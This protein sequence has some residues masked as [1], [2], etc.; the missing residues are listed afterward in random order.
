[1]PHV[2]R[3]TPIAIAKLKAG[4]S[5]YEVSE[6]ASPLRI[7]VQTSGHKSG[8]IRYRRPNTRETAKW[9]SDIPVTDLAALRKDAVDAAFM[10]SQG[11]DPGKAKQATE[12]KEAEVRADTFE[13]AVRTYIK[14]ETGKVKSMRWREK[15][16]ERLIL[17]TLGHRPVSTITL[18]E[19]TALCDTVE[20]E[21]GPAMADHAFALIRRVMRWH[22]KRNGTT[23]P[24]LL[25]EK[26]NPN[27]ARSRI[28]TDNEWRLGW[29]H[30]ETTP[31]VFPLFWMFLLH[32]GCR[33]GEAAGM[34]WSELDGD[35]WVL[36]PER[37]K[38]GLEVVRPLSK[39]ALR[40]LEDVPRVGPFVF[41]AT[42]ARPLS[43]FV[44]PKK[45]F[46]KAAGISGYTLHDLRRSSRSMMSRAGVQADV[47]EMLLGH[48]VGGV[49]GIYDRHSFIN[50]KRHGYE[51]LAR[52]I[53]AIVRPVE[54]NVVAM[55]R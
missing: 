55:V 28:L 12:E 46:D 23:V 42:G 44:K 27:G 45:T 29:A 48:R 13:A 37:S 17:G 36:P 50:E 34:M 31:G 7:F 4:V 14:R 2:R 35:T 3:F 43:G 21:R 47:A 16:F 9:T 39:A 40:L 6:D 19:I 11:A 20:D 1:M 52:Q 41:S 5:R 25:G 53:E 32:T 30:A 10:V 22:A 49:R 33:R 38:N 26:R 51:L 24:V 15:A 8:G 18:K 54:G